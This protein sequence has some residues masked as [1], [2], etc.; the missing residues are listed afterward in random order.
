MLLDVISWQMDIN[1]MNT[2]EAD[3]RPFY[4]DSVRQYSRA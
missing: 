4:L 1:N 2:L 3:K